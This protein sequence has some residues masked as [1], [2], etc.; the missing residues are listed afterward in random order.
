MFLSGLNRSQKLRLFHVFNHA[1]SIW[2]IYHYGFHWLPLSLLIWTAI[3]SFGISIGFHRLLSHRSFSTS[4]LLNIV[5]P[6]IGCLATGGSPLGWAG[7]HRL[8]HRYTDRPGDPHSWQGIGKLRV[9][10][11]MWDQV[12]VPKS[13]VKDLIKNPALR[14][15]HRHYFKILLSWAFL[16]YAIH[17]AAGAFGY[18]LP[19]VFAFHA[20]G[21][22]NLFGHVHGY[23]NFDTA[24][25]STNSWIANLL[26]CG[27]GW[28]N[29]HHRYPAHYRI[30]LK[31]NEIDISAWLLER[32]PIMNGAKEHF[33]RNRRILSALKPGTE[34]NDG[35][36]S[37]VS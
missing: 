21:L 29:N 31:P 4:P 3:G 35:L 30:G 32:L 22:I 11:H 5:L 13:M 23:R 36:A 24:D 12:V 16:L 14:W 2:A 17:P 28:H 25:T 10:T 9:Y 18:S 19:A 27:E 15:M 8:H 33:A 1:A 20:F 34:E 7:A 37:S 6:A 26:T